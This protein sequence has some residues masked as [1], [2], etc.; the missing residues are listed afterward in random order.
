MQIPGD[1]R[2][3]RGSPRYTRGTASSNGEVQR[4]GNISGIIYEPG[5]KFLWP[6]EMT[7]KLR[8][9][10]PFPTHYIRGSF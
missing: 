6:R 10:E 7:A 2:V 4:Q 1:I 3:A 8:P 5:V 9:K